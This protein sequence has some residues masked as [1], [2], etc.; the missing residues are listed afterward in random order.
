MTQSDHNTT[1]L[2]HTVYDAIDALSI[3]KGSREH[4]FGVFLQMRLDKLHRST[5]EFAAEVDL[6]QGV[7][8]LLVAGQIPS[9]FIS[10]AAIARIAQ[11]VREDIHVLNAFLGRPTPTLPLSAD[12]IAEILADE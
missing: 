12:E 10:D 1:D 7:I 6:P 11:G 3:K 4:V 2:H 5:Q 9:W 8:D